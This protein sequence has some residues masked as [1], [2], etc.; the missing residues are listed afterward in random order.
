MFPYPSGAGLHVGHSEGYT[1]TDIITPLEADAGVPTC[2]TRWAGTPS[3]CRPRTT[4]SRHGVH[5][6]VTTAAAIANFKRQIDAVG[7]SYDWTREI[8]TT[9]PGYM[10]VD[11]VDLPAALPAGPGLRGRHPHQLVPVM[12]D[13][14]RQRRGE[15]G[16]AASAAGR[17]SSAR[18]CASGSCASPATPIA[19]W[20]IWTGSTGLSSTLAM[21]RNWIG[22]SEGAEVIFQSAG[23]P[24]AGT[25]ITRLHHAPR[26]AL[27]RDLHGARARAR[28]GRRADH[29]RAARGGRRAYQE[30]A[31][32]KSDLERTEL[33][34]EK[35]GVF[36]GAY[37]DQPGHRQDDPDLD[38]R[39][40]AGRATAPAPSWPSRRTTSATSPSP[41]SSRLPIVQ[42]VEPPDGTHARC[43]RRR[44]P[45][46]ASAVNSGLLD[47]LATPEAKRKIIARSGGARP[48]PGRGQLR[49]RDWVFSR[50]RYWGEPIPL[51][52]C[53]KDGVVPVPEYAAAGAPAGGRDLRADRHRRV[54][55]GGDR[56]LGQHHLPQVRRPGQ[57]RDQHHAP[58]GGLVLVLPALHRSRRTT[59]RA[60]RPEVE[61]A[62]DGRSTSTSAAP[63]TRSCTCFTRASGTR[64]SSTWGIVSHQGAVPEAAP[65]GDGARRTRTRTA[66]GATTSPATSS[67]AA[68]SRSC[69]RPARR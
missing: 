32:R 28:A 24:V 58:V 63:S 19:C 69:G 42:V 3:A 45:T 1:A 48:R 40:R 23:S 14:P 21:Q 16:G 25:E 59:A 35:T 30:E 56:E 51:V 11:A 4:P 26:H 31:R 6:R 67:C 15:P 5:P 47:G 39:L 10:Q 22:R 61:K 20:R 49:L 46:T 52:H 38:R 9:D 33:A 34:K 12:Q 44:S 43:R 36:T 13:R 64:C 50:Q 55:A 7:F 62:M 57:A 18:T 68:T 66:W 8:D 37:G 60:G 17:R 2:C 54:A 27:R 65:P 53:P 29:A 41:R